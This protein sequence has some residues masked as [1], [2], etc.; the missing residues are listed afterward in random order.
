L[1]SISTFHQR[2][3][4]QVIAHPPGPKTSA[5]FPS[6]E[7]SGP[8]NLL[9]DSER[10][11]VVRLGFGVVAGLLEKEREIIQGV[12]GLG[13]IR[14]QTLCQFN[15]SFR[16]QTTILP[17]VEPYKPISTQTNAS[18]LLPPASRLLSP[19][20]CLLSPDFSATARPAERRL[21]LKSSCASARGMLL[22]PD[23]CRL[24]HTLRKMWVTWH[25]TTQS[26]TA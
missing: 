7:C 13:A 21:L 26:R 17:A 18:C 6:A 4:W 19:V 8:K 5:M 24:F 9:S 12:G 3:R 1:E 2:A 14:T 25:L 10:F 11:P 23:S 16:K 20:S 22:T 15:C